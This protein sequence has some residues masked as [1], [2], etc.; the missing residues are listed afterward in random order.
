[1][2]KAI[3]LDR[4]GTI[5]E[6]TGYAHKLEDLILFPEAVKG[7]KMLKDDYMFFIITNQPGIGKGLFTI[8]D[9]R[10]FN[11]QLIKTLNDNDITIERTYFCPHTGG[12][13]CRKPSTRYVHEI[14]S[15]YSID[16]AK[17]WVIGDH[18]SD[19]EMG[20]RAG[21]KTVYLLTGHGEKHLHEL[22]SKMIEPTMIA[23]DFLHAA[24]GVKE[25]ENRDTKS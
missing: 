16:L 23:P 25:Y 7:L 17:S 2:K 20:N 4:D 12:C 18:P 3:F 1:M 5:I 8:E 13:D 11:N 19:I 15:E 14:L 24:V 6:D 22:E 21:C 9:F 10:T